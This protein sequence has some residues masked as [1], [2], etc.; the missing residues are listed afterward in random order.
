MRRML[1]TRAPAISLCALLALTTR[2]VPQ[3]AVQA[4]APAP[5]ATQAP[6]LTDSLRLD[7]TVR[8]GVLPNGMRYFIKRNGRPEARVSLRLVVGAGSTVEADDQQGLAHF[9]EHMNFNGSKHFKDAD[10]LVAYLQQIGLRFGADANAYTTFDETVYMLEVP[11]DRDTL[12]DRGLNALS[13]FAG[14]ATFSQKEIDKE[15]GV[16]L[17]EWRL[18]RGADERVQRKEW[19]LIFHGSRYADRIP[20]GKPDIIQKAPPSRLRDY[21]REWYTPER[22]AVVAVGDIDPARMDSLIR[23]HF[24]D[25]NARPSSKP[26]PRFDIPKHPETLISVA[27]D[28]ELTNSGIG[29]WF[30]HARRSRGTLADFRRG[31]VEGLLSSMMNARF[32][33]IE[34]HSDSPFLG[35]GAYGFPLGRTMEAFAL[36]ASVSDGGIEKGLAALLEEVARVRQ[37]GFLDVELQRAKDRLLA[38]NERAYRERDKSESSGFAGQ[39][40]SHY[41]TGDPVPGIEATYR[42]T[43]ELLP[44]ITLADVGRRIPSLTHPDS[45]VVLASA[46]DKKGLAAP[47]EQGLRAILDRAADA[48]VAAWVDTSAGKPLM[49]VLPTPGT[50]TG[51]SVIEEIGTTVLSLSNGVEVWLKP[52]DFK[53]DE[54]VFTSYALGGLSLADS[55]DFVTALLTNAVIDDAGVGGFKDTD[56]QKMLSGRIVRVSP[57]YGAYTHGLTGG[58]RPSDLEVTLQLIHMSFAQV[59]EDADGFAALKK[60]LAAFFADR[61]NSPEQV[62]VDTLNTVNT[63]RFYMS[64]VP[65]GEAVAAVKL[66]PVLDFHKRRFANAADFTFFFAGSFSVDSIA[67]LLARYLGSLPSTG[68]RASAFRSI[69][70]RYPDGVIRRQ[71]HKGVEPKASTRITFFTHGGI[72]ELDMHRARAAASILTDHLRETLRELL[73]GTYGASAFFSTQAPLPGYTTTSIAF[74][75]APEN[76]DK[77]VAATLAEVKKLRD[78]GPSDAD[79]RKDQEVERRELEVALKQNATW[80]GSLL[81]VHQYGWDPRRIAKRRER[82]DLLT[83]ENLKES[84]RKYYPLDHYSVVTLLPVMGGTRP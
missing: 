40:V 55:V 54:I 78:Q 46:P 53:A 37:H 83:T 74:G 13:D 76:V 2:A 5:A 79:L 68:K 65:T 45:R 70:P 3:G 75:C 82:I 29:I 16:V 62:F 69:G 57:I 52:T 26:T 61:A 73:G 58:T 63:G 15:R 4:Q 77:M 71:V 50:I 59:T 27:T 44:G 64:Q 49:A 25:L 9:A 42:L 14:R 20:I 84:F 32:D 39:Y 17:E 38:Q 6:A 60:R 8:T 28:P 21:Y 10:D 43:K 11:T 33:E 24:A 1:L 48:P 67:P 30:K 7:P 47:S 22:M 80:S 31:L 41:L 34:H 18:G 81:A 66:A 19:P 23:V 36:G 35:A 72:E 12:L 51:R 56:L